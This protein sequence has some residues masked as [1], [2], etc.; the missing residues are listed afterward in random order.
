MTTE[1]NATQ[2]DFQSR[3]RGKVESILKLELQLAA[4]TE[5]MTPK[6]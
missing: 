3:G 2:L 5:Q 6:S 4:L 1:C